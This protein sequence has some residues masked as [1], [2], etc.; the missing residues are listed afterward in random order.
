MKRWIRASCPAQ[1]ASCLGDRALAVS[2]AG[3]SPMRNSD[4]RRPPRDAAPMH[5]DPQRGLTPTS[6]QRRV[7]LHDAIRPVRHHPRKA[8]HYRQHLLGIE[9]RRAHFSLV[10]LPLRPI[11]VLGRQG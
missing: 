11:L 8:K 5:A 6:N 7:R 1:R 4:P 9:E 10:K 3:R 2:C